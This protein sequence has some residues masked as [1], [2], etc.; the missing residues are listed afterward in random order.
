MNDFLKDNFNNNHIT[1]FIE[2][3]QKIIPKTQ[4]YNLL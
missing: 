2:L 1:T 4:K 3:I